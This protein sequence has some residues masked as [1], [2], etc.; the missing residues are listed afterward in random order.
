MVKRDIFITN[1]HFYPSGDFPAVVNCELPE[2][3]CSRQLNLLQ[4][5][6]R[7][8]LKKRLGWL[9]R[10]KRSWAQRGTLPSIKNL[11]ND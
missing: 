2:K 8:R 3:S 5:A 7:I 9:N 10:K 1:F 4:P 6:D 11:R